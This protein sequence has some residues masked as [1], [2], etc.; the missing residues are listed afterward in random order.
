[1]KKVTDYITDIKKSIL[2]ILERYDVK[3]ASIVGSVARGEQT[4]HSDLDVVVDISAPLSLLSFSRM[5]IEIED[6]L[7]LKVDLI[8]RSAIKPRLKEFL[9]AGEVP[10]CE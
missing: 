6:K 2:P 10:I 7:N 9:L 4:S 3:S 5:K 8:E 1:M